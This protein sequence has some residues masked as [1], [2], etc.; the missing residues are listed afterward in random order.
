MLRTAAF[1]QRQR[2]RWR[3]RRRPL[4]TRTQQKASPDNRSANQAA[5]D[6]RGVMVS[7]EGAATAR[8]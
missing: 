4:A 1:E 3:R 8:A 5:R 6:A 2:H 7:A